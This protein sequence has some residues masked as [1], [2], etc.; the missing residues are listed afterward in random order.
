MPFSTLYAASL[1]LV[2]GVGCG[3]K[4]EQIPNSKNSG[5]KQPV[6]QPVKQPNQKPLITFGRFVTFSNPFKFKSLAWAP[7]PA[8]R[9]GGSV[10]MITV[11]LG[12]MNGVELWDADNGKLIKNFGKQRIYKQD[13]HIVGMN[14]AWNPTG[15]YLASVGLFKRKA[16]TLPSGETSSVSGYHLDGEIVIWK[17]RTIPVPRGIVPMGSKILTLRTG[18]EPCLA[19]SPAGNVLAT[20]HQ[21][22]HVQL[23]TLDGKSYG[24]SPQRQ[25]NIKKRLPSHMSAVWDVAWGPKGVW[26]AS[27]DNREV[28]IW[29]ISTRQEVRS[30]EGTGEIAWSPDGTKLARSVGRTRRGSMKVKLWD[31][32][33]GMDILEIKLRDE[34]NSNSGLA[35]SPDSKKLA[36]RV[37]DQNVGEIKIWD[38]VTGKE[39]H[40]LPIP[41]GED[42]GAKFAWNPDGTK[43]AILSDS[44]SIW[45]IPK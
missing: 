27:S 21:S 2:L 32:A 16:I 30:L 3:K 33:T 17:F 40:A 37:G 10:A 23:W 13:T 28:K 18:P 41:G 1:A 15:E 38:A 14:N 22:G 42:N 9:T 19:W 20:G 25:R 44:I 39:L 34:G 11:G 35:W 24:L 43:L 7:H 12:G 4:E 45:S 8:R 26:L 31:T 36:A 5:T 6:K 29:R